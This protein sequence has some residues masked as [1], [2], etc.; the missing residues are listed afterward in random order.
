MDTRSAHDRPFVRIMLTDMSM[1]VTCQCLMSIPKNAL[2]QDA[3]TTFE[4]PT[5]FEHTKNMPTTFAKNP[6]NY[7]VPQVSGSMCRLCR[8]PPR[9]QPRFG[10]LV[11]SPTFTLNPHQP[12]LSS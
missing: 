7:E 3:P 8:M 1:T 12:I 11:L 6:N 9:M 2:G 10:I 4:M 5:T